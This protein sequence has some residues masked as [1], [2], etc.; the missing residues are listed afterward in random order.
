MG[1]YQGLELKMV[2]S[3]GLD[4]TSILSGKWRRYFSWRNFGIFLK[5]Y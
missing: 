4:Y 5:L 3:E 1:T 2:Q